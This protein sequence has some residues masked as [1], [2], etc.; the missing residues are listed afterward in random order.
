MIRLFL[1][2]CLLFACF[3]GINAQ[4]IQSYANKNSIDF[5]WGAGFSNLN[6]SEHQD[7]RIFS[8]GG[9]SGLRYTRFLNDHWGMF[10]QFD[11]SACNSSRELFFNK[12]EELDGGRYVY[13][14][15][16][17]SSSFIAFTKKSYPKSSYDGIFV[18]AAYRRDFGLWSIRPRLG[19]GYADFYLHRY[20]YYRADPELETMGPELVEV[21]IDK[22]NSSSSLSIA[23][24]ALKA[25]FQVKFSVTE[26]FH[27]SAEVD[28][29]MFPLSYANYVRV[30]DT[31]PE[32]G[33]ENWFDAII[34]NVWIDDDFRITETIY[35]HE[36]RR[37]IPD[38]VSLRFGFGWDF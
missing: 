10:L 22:D 1:S 34:D 18:G 19:I 9:S 31:V 11:V 38:S 35:D 12:L 15:R 37:G 17:V 24:L 33:P 8:V 6:I 2:V 5:S 7:G 20:S 16:V 21:C 25:S 27:L 36:V 23:T 28:Y 26:H 14:K 3:A 30:H 32:N 4:S 13:S 29:T